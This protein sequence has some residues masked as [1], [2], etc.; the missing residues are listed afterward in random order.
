MSEIA[1][2][3]VA[4]ARVVLR[5]SCPLLAGA[6]PLFLGIFDPKLHVTNQFEETIQDTL[7]VGPCMPMTLAESLVRRHIPYG[8]PSLFEY[9]IDQIDNKNHQKII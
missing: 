3:L 1:Q 9:Q 4:G 5:P 8:T 2:I 7:A 6:S